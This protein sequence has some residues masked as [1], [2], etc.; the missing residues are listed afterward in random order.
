MGQGAPIV[1]S[2]GVRARKER[3]LVTCGL[4]RG[5]RGQHDG[6]K[7]EQGEQRAFE[8]HEPHRCGSSGNSPIPGGT[9]PVGRVGAVAVVPA[10]AV[11]C[12]GGLDVLTFSGTPVLTLG[13]ASTSIVAMVG[14]GAVTTVAVVAT[15]VETVGACVLLVAD[16]VGAG[17][18]CVASFTIPTP[19]AVITP[20]DRAV[21]KMMF[22]TRCRFPGDVGV[23]SF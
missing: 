15:T 11:E 3:R 13:S 12:V 1:R 21:A 9:L 4:G 23:S 18:S 10:D 5:R 17:P 6:A 22:R 2:A 19:S 8:N 14:G 20:N 7:N 16:P